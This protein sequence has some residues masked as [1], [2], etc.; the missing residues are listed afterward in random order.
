[1]MHSKEL[2]RKQKIK[3]N[4]AQ[5]LE[6]HDPMRENGYANLKAIPCSL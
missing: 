3:R 2:L 4:N 1:M 6:T 5:L